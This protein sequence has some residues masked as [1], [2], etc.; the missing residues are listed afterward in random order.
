MLLSGKE[1]PRNPA[2]AMRMLDRGC[3]S[4]GT[5]ICFE[6]G[7]RLEKEQGEIHHAAT[8][9]DL[10]CQRGHAAACFAF[11]HR[12]WFGQGI[13]MDRGVAVEKWR[14]ACGRGMAQ[15][16]AI[17]QRVSFPWQLD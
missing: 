1:I 2:E 11:G 6:Y 14:F 3:K 9:Y 4:H 8:L 17:L 10:A 16:C 15:A 7:Q 13:G 12:R 5:E